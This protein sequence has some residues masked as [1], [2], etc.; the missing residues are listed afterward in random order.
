MTYTQGSLVEM[1]PNIKSYFT[2]ATSEIEINL[3]LQLA[4]RTSRLK[5]LHCT[6]PTE[7]LLVL[8][9][10][11]SSSVDFC[12]LSSWISPHLFTFVVKEANSGYLT[13]LL[14]PSKKK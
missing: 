7:N 9:K 11:Y 1:I 12:F 14:F 5:D 8:Q 10:S 2:Q 6:G 4:S 13:I 3:K